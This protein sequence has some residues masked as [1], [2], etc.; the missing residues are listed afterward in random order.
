M[1][2]DAA[3]LEA[4][5]GHPGDKWDALKNRVQA[6]NIRSFAEVEKAWLDLTRL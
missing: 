4:Q 5:V 2:D 3:A 1:A 6:E